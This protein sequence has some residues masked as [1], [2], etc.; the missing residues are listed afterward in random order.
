MTHRHL[1]PHSRLERKSL[2]A[3]LAGW[4][5]LAMALSSPASA[6]PSQSAEALEQV[7]AVEELEIVPAFVPNRTLSFKELGARYPLNLRGVDASNSLPFNIRSDE[8]VKGARVSLNYA[9]SPA[10]LSDLSHI[11]VLINDEVA[12]T[13]PVPRDTAGVNLQRMVELPS[14]LITAN[15]QLRLQLIGHYTLECEDPLHSSLWANISNHSTLDL[16]VDPLLLPNDLAL[17]PVPF[18][19]PRDERRLTLPFVFSGVADNQVLEGAGALASWF[20]A[21]AGSRG[22]SF[23]AAKDMAPASGNAI[24]L[25]NGAAQARHFY[26]VALTGPTLAVVAN[27]QDPSGKLLL[28]MGRDGNEL[29]QAALALAGGNQTFSGQAAVITQLAALKPR[30]PYDAPNWL[31]TDRPVSFG[32]ITDEKKMNVT[33]YSPDLIRLNVR[34]PP[35]LFGWRE[36]RV[37]I[38]LKY[39]YTPQPTSVNS[40]LLFSVDDLFVKSMPLFSLDNLYHGESVRAQ[41]LPDESLPSETMIRVPLETLLSRAQLQFRYMYDYIKQGECRDIIIDNV[42]GYIDPESTIDLTAYPHYKAMPDLASF[43]ESGWPFTRLADLSETAVVLDANAS[44]PELTTY[45]DLMGMMGE[46]TGYPALA[47]T[48]T[49]PQQI[50]NVSDKDI[51]VI[52]GGTDQ[53]LLKQWAD[54]LTG[55]YTSQDGKRFGTSDLI[56]KTLNW[57]NPN[58]RYNEEAQRALLAY[59]SDGV[60]AIVAG[61]ESPISTGR[62]VVLVASNKPEGLDSASAAIRAEPGFETGIAGSL[63]IIRDKRVDPLIADQTYYMG[64]LGFFKRI[65]WMLD[66]YLPHK[67]W[68]A[69]LIGVLVL[70]L[71]VW[72]VAALIRR[73][74]RGRRATRS[75]S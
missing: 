46:S 14:H 73:L 61:F 43:A 24:V 41:V 33:G 47:V 9:Y 31:R 12:A 35:D 67:P 54:T 42:R 59:D 49:Q 64:Q 75:D 19:D 6:E 27:P 28:V 16:A 4:C 70:L 15:N 1:V 55:N 5:M 62:S 32:E 21:L 40:S 60:N 29:K 44:T 63:S 68:V 69:I 72:L 50:D 56:Y 58:P 8:I 3:L 2:S 45:L 74:L 38:H 22:A 48:I 71:L 65:Q 26:D 52:T 20:G 25:V 7:Q 30:V 23:P 39:R 37:P 34:V 66:P 51:L 17:L 13:I 53:P 11:N 36:D 10:L 18:F 57:Q